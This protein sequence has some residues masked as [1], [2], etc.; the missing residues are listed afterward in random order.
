MSKIIKPEEAINLSKRFREENRII[1]LA[2]G[3]FDIL[4]LG[5]V[6]FLR[7]AKKRGDF[8]FILLESDEA[9]KKI[10]GKNRPI[11]SQ[12]DRAKVLEALCDVDF[13]V[14]IPKLETDTDYD[15]LISEI[16]PSI[17]ATTKG[18]PFRKHKERQAE[19]IK[20]QVVDVIERKNRKSTSRLAKLISEDFYL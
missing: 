14:K 2:G 15:E 13:V 19:I 10:K 5:H 4:H 1:V 7:E 11:N 20:G 9:I 12:E 8:L 16:K 6:E 3:C 17:I 18:D